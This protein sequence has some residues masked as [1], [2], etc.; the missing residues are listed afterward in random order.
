MTNSLKK[1]KKSKIRF[2]VDEIVFHEP[3]DIDRKELKEIIRENM[4]NQNDGSKKANITIDSIRAIFDNLIDNAS[5]DD[6]TD[7][8]ML[9]WENE[10]SREMIRLMDSVV[11]LIKE[12]MEDVIREYIS[13]LEALNM[14]LLNNKVKDISN[15]IGVKLDEILSDNNIDLT[16]EEMI[17]GLKNNKTI[18]EIIKEKNVLTKRVE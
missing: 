5:L 18:D 6:F 8:E 15:N 4:I 16:L 13:E 7:E 11:D 14:A 2:T 9:N 1:Y 17:L 3:S 10:M 12:I